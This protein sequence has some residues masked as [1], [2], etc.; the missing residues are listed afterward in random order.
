[1]EKTRYDRHT[2]RSNINLVFKTLSS[3]L[4]VAHDLRFE[5]DRQKKEKAASRLEFIGNDIKM[6]EKCGEISSSLKKCSAD[7]DIDDLHS[8]HDA[9]RTGNY[10]QNLIEEIYYQGMN[11]A[12]DAQV[13]QAFAPQ[14]DNASPGK[15]KYARF[16]RR[17]R[18]PSRAV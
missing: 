9:I 13:Y 6:I 3:L 16:S 8:H 2:D 4:D 15:R 11:L 7:F 18:L 1:M 10:S 14:K 12:I 5:K 17:A